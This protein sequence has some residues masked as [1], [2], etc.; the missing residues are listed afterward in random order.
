MLPIPRNPNL[1]PVSE[2]DFL[3]MTQPEDA[4]LIATGAWDDY[5][6]EIIET[7]EQEIEELPIE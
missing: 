2:A 7:P 3:D 5:P 1:P 6:D 4:A